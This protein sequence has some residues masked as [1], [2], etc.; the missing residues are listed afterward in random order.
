[1]RSASAQRECRFWYHHTHCA[2]CLLFQMYIMFREW[3]IYYTS[4]FIKCPFS[5]MRSIL[6]GM[7]SA[8]ITGICEWI[9][10][11]LLLTRTCIDNHVQCMCIE[12][13]LTLGSVMYVP[14][15]THMISSLLNDGG[16]KSSSLAFPES[17]CYIQKIRVVSTHTCTHT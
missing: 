3:A 15:L 9:Q 1:M 16:R 6:L 5:D 14:G 8:T 2:S 10:A 7:G 11:M 4:L 12:D 17:M 13:R